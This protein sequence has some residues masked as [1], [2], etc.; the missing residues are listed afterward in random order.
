MINE[1]ETDLGTVTLSENYSSSYDGTFFQK[2]T[3]L[4]I[5]K[6]MTSPT[7]KRFYKISGTI[8]W[9]SDKEV[10]NVNVANLSKRRTVTIYSA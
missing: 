2:G 7:G 6:I 5:Q 8:N 3:I 9:I 1:T 10:C 4:K